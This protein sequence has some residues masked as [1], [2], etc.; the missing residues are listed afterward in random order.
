MLI[1]SAGDMERNHVDVEQAFIQADV[2]DNIL[3]ELL[4]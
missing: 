4:K 2:K 3:I 1:A